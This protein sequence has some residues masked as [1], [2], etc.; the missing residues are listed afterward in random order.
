MHDRKKMKK[1]GLRANQ[2]GGVNHEKSRRAGTLHRPLVPPAPALGNRAVQSLLKPGVRQSPRL[3]RPGDRHE[4]EADRRAER[5]MSDV[6][7]GAGPRRGE[8]STSERDA[9]SRKHD[10]FSRPSPSIR[11]SGTT[12]RPV[13]ESLRKDFEPQFGYDFSSVRF[14]TD[15]Q[16]AAL[17]RLMNARAFTAG[18][19]VFFG[20]GEYAPDTAAGK[21]LVAHELSHVLQQTSDAGLMHAGRTVVQRAVGAGAAIH[22]SYEVPLIPQPTRVSCW[23]AALAMV[24]S[25]RDGTTYTPQ[26][27]AAR[28]GMNVNTGYGWSDISGAVLV[29]G[30]SE[31]APMSA[32]PP[33]WADML[34]DHG[35][36]WVVEVGA[37]YHAVV[38]YG[39]H[40]TG[41]PD[42]T[43]VWV[44]NPWPPNQGAVEYK[45]FMDFDR[46]F[47]LGAGA[48]ASI[49]HA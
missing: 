40:G 18:Q 48:N 42:S 11:P 36:L 20:P 19:D 31:T 47:G 41:D 3:S 29:W 35:P 2:G 30:L 4:R 43:E 15:P 32:L 22:I 5:V 23:A 24:A 27:I 45:T 37:P 44:K 16:S 17:A 12:G 1:K 34:E 10:I 13:P 25:H 33:Y 6:R 39:M 9:A 46:E 28:A 49:V 14:H 8:Q 7:R 21:E 26:E 38:V